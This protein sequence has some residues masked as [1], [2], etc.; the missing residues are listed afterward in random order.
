[1]KEIGNM[2][3]LITGEKGRSILYLLKLCIFS[4]SVLKS[5]FYSGEKEKVSEKLCRNNVGMW[6][7]TEMRSGKL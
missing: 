5:P 6:G 3:P 2:F 4:S 7:R 1:M